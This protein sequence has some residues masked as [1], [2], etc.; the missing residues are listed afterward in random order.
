MIKIFFAIMLLILLVIC[1]IK[2]KEGFTDVM[3]VIARYNEKLDWL[4]EEPFNK[5]PVTIYNKGP[6]DDFYKPHNSKIVK[7]KNVGRCD[8]TYV[9]HIIQNYDNLNDITIF[10]PGSTNMENKIE[11]SKLLFQKIEQTNKAVFLS[12]NINMQDLYHFQLDEWVA[13]STE[14]S[15][16]NPESKLELSSIRPFG[17]W[18]ESRFGNIEITRVTYYGIFSVSSKDITQH[19]KSYYEELIKDVNNSSNPEAGHYFERSWQAIFYPMTD[20]LID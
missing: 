2:Y 10:L 1:G 18:L 9:Y 6:N 14:N 19:P 7:V 17:K 5:Y 4:K 16:I 15:S 20:T 3:I 12:Q 8:H 11:H 13:S